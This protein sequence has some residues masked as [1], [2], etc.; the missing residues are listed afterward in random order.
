MESFSIKLKTG[1][2]ISRKLK[3]VENFTPNFMAW[4]LPES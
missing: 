4:R 3:R 1:D 2:L